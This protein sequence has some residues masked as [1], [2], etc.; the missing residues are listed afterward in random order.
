VI[1]ALK[2]IIQKSDTRQYYA[3]PGKWVGQITQALQ[4][5][6]LPDALEEA[7]KA[8]LPKGC[9]VLLLKFDGQQYDVE[10]NL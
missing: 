7:R 2:R 5:D 10:L 6:S 4:F 3:G 8:G 9:C 1:E